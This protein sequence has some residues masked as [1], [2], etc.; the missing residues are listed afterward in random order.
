MSP[1]DDDAHHSQPEQKSRVVTILAGFI[2]D[3]AAGMWAATMLAI[4]WL[5]N[6]AVPAE[7]RRAL[8]AMEVRFFWI[9]LACAA[10][11]IIAGTGRTF[12]YAATAGIYGSDAEPLRKRMLWRKH[13]LLV[14]VFALGTAWQYWMVFR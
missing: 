10:I 1:R 5:D 3:F 2:H 6:A 9:A 4:F 11:V 14:A 13:V 12:T 8:T 7:A